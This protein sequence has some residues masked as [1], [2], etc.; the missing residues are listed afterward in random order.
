MELLVS[1]TWRDVPGYEGRYQIS[2]IGNVRCVQRIQHHKNGVMRFQPQKN[3]SI[4]YCKNWKYGYG[5]VS[6]TDNAGVQKRTWVHRLV[7][8]AFIPNPENKPQVNHK[9][10]DKRNNRVENLEWCTARENLM[11]SFNTGLHSQEPF[12]RA[13]RRPVIVVAPSGEMIR[14]DTVGEAAIFMGYKYESNLSRDLHT[15][16]GKCKNGFYAYREDG[17]RN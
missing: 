9:D 14:F 16:G 7:A 10:G 13:G 17:K 4:C 6:L 11:H 15:R 1:E 3:L 8:L 5:H 2:S 12:L